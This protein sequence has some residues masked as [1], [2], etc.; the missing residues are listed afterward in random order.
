MASKKKGN[1]IKQNKIKFIIFSIVVIAVVLLYVVIYL[2]FKGDGFFSAG[3]DLAK[4]DWLS[5]LGA[6]ISFVGTVLVSLI[7]LFQSSYYAK[8]ENERRL[9][10]HRKKIQPIFS[11]DIVSINTQIGGTVEFFNPSDPSTYPKHNNI[12]ISFE[13]ANSYPITN[14][15]VFD[16]Y[17]CPLLK[18]NERKCLLCAYYDS[19]DAKKWEKKLIEIKADYERNEKGIPKWFNICYEDI[20]GQEMFQTFELKY[21][22]DTPYYSVEGT[23]EA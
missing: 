18:C 9:Q 5:F 16:N 3:K 13:N 7:A 17:I 19:D 14:V 6:Y 4:S 2:V 12:R 11:V 8:T 22:D 10:E 21:L 20:D 23:Y 15:I 1:V